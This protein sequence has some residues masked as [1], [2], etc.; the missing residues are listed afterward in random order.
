MTGLPGLTSLT[1]DEIAAMFGTAGEADQFA[2]VAEMERRDAA[3]AKAKAHGRYR[4]TG[5]AADWYEAAH[6]QYLAAD[7]A[8]AGTLLSADG[9]A[10]TS[11]AM[12]LWTGSEKWAR[13]LASE[14]L[15][16]FWDDNH[17]RLT[18]AKYREQAAASRRE[19][20]EAY[21]YDAM[22]S[23]DA[24][25][26]QH[27]AEASA[28]RDVPAARPVRD[29][30]HGRSDRSGGRMTA[31][32][33]EEA[34]GGLSWNA[35]DAAE[36]VAA[37][38]AAV[39]D[40][41]ARPSV[42]DKPRSV[43]TYERAPLIAT[44]YEDID[45]LDPEWL[46]NGH[47]AR[48]E[49]S[50]LAGDGGIG[51]G[52]LIADLV[53]RVTRGD[54]MPGQTEGTRPGHVIMIT[55]E[56]SPQTSCARRLRAA[57]A[58]LGMVHDLTE[59]T[60]GP[61]EIPGD[62]PVLR[63]AIDEIGDV[64]MVVIDPLSAVSSVSL[65]TANRVRQQIMS[66]LQRLARDTGVAMVV[67]HHTVKSGAIAGSKTITDAARSVMTVSLDEE[68]T[69]IRVLEVTKSN[70]ASK[71]GSAVRYVVEGEW[72]ATQVVYLPESAA[73]VSE[74]SDV[75]LSPALRIAATAGD[76]Q[77]R[78]AQQVAREAG[79]SYQLARQLLARM[80]SAG[81]IAQVT[82]GVYQAVS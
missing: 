46:W 41:Y 14:E 63:A 8:C 50:I 21:R 58:E 12:T 19:E 53:A 67:V 59:T 60:A 9:I 24:R 49:V 26:I 80:E 39:P 75:S 44:P 7:A 57:G 31:T 27:R 64:A 74:G 25:C 37:A 79:C 6:A 73:G 47:F 17:G 23:D 72:P 1:D 22:D 35:S 40:A 45:P 61:F 70:I 18:P 55:P 11:E 77:R 78:T 2:I 34:P 71:T 51:K 76:G 48:A 42:P 10:E 52:F 43:L 66:P 29:A 65:S 54:P 5:D 69:R 30:G 36:P 38:P 4:T 81:T 56:D 20:R 3:D 15:K 82:Q 33:T 62:L 32:I 28:R 16:N 68:D 13:R